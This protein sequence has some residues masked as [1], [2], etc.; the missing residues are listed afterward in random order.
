MQA[1]LKEKLEQVK[2][3]YEETKNEVARIQGALDVRK[4][5]LLT[6]FEL[7]SIDEAQ[8]L[9]DEYK[10]QQKRVEKELKELLNTL[11][12]MLSKHEQS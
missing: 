12:R 1:E 10:K 7:Q 6:E 11:E 5:E 8:S 4:K 3:E 9:L 2:Q